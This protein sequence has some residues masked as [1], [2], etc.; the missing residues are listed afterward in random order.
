MDQPVEVRC[1]AV[2]DRHLERVE[3]QVS[4]QRPRRLPADDAPGEH[5]DDER[6]VHPAA[7]GLDVGQVGDP[8]PVRPVSHEVSFDQVGRPVASDGADRCSRR[9]A[10]QR[11]SQTELAHQPFHGAARHLDAFAVELGPHLGGAIDAVVLGVD[12]GDVDLKLV[13]SQRPS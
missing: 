3:R 6:H 8:E 4:T 13:V 12:P 2:P 5:V 11:A 1:G 10:P 9:L 7:V